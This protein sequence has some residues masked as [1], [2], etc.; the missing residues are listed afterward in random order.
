MSN[1]LPTLLES[2]VKRTE[3]VSEVLIAKPDSPEG[4]VEKWETNGIKFEKFGTFYKKRLIYDKGIQMQ[5]AEHAINIHLCI[6]KA[7][8]DD[9]FVMD[10]DTFLY[11]NV[12]K[13]FTEL[14]EKH[15]LQYIGVS[16]NSA[17]TWA[18]TYFPCVFGCLFNKKD[19]PN[20]NFM[21]GEIKYT[22][23]VECSNP[24]KQNGG[25]SFDGKYLVPGIHISYTKEYPNPNGQYDTSSRLWVWS[26]QQNWKWLSFQTLDCHTYTTKYYRSNFKLKENMPLQKLLYHSVGGS[27]NKPDQFAEY[28]RAWQAS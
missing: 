3:L 17:L 9:V 6:D 27:H 16:H 2:V 19:M 13:I 21:K 12:D 7:K 22:G 25:E 14:K 1:Y 5:G 24:E 26:K 8:N 11:S 20:K 4:E 18:F 10:G 23:E 28:S 15:N